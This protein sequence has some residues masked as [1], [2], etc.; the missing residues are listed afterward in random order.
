MYCSK[1]GRLVNDAL[2]YCKNCGEKLGKDKE[3]ESP[4]SII[5][6]LLTTLCFVVLG[7]LGILIGL[8][9]VLLENKINPSSVAVIAVFYL[10]AIAAICYLL[11]S[12][13]P[14]L[15]DANIN[16]NVRKDEPAQPA[17]LSAPTT[18]QLEEH[19][20]PVTSVT[21]NTTRNFEKIPLKHD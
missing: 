19:R 17:Q 6:D 10:A 5:D 2:K 1:C 8:V 4:K 16:Q 3:K 9:A 15:I 14:K 21:E 18:A 7:G 12:P 13:L 20:E 11:L